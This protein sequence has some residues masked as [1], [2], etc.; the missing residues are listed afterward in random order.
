MPPLAPYL[1]GLRSGAVRALR[2]PDEIVVRLGFYAIVLLVFAALW[3]AAVDANGGELGGYSYQAL[4]WYTI[5]AEAAVIATKPRLIE[6][7]GEEIASGDVA[8]ALLRPIDVA[9]FRL[10]VELGEA[11]V[12]LVGTCLLGAVLGLLFAGRP[13]ELRDAALVLVAAPLAVT[14]NLAAQL[15]F[16]ACAFWLE[17]AKA[18]WFL[19]QKL[20][21][22]LGGMLLPLELLPGWL[23]DIARALPF[24]AMSYVPARM[25]S[26]HASPWLFAWQIG[27]LVVLGGALLATFHAGERRLTLAGG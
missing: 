12:R 19:Y 20:I 4:V 7:V 5:G 15:T 22:L 24:A 17:D 10:A 14:V 27:W 18:G 25:A 21:F 9:S 16:A 11:L 23:S 6:E 3:R 26:G 2:Q 1:A 13:P 8:L